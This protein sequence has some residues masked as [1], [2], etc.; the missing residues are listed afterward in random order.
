MEEQKSLADQLKSQT[1]TVAKLEKQEWIER[2]VAL[3]EAID[4]EEFI[5]VPG[6]NPMTGG[7]PDPE[8]VRKRTALT[9][10]ACDSLKAKF[11][12]EGRDFFEMVS[13]GP[14]EDPTGSQYVIYFTRR[15]ASKSFLIHDDIDNLHA[16][17]KDITR[18]YLDS[19]PNRR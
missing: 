4:R 5:R 14:N 2:G 11:G 3:T 7:V 10:E 17:A 6:I 1:E 19:I 16:D 18:R 8:E 9:K 15:E 12:Q 13:S